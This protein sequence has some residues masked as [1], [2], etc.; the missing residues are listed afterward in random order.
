MQNVGS[1]LQL[2]AIEEAAEAAAKKSQKGA[3]G[4]YGP[5]PPPRQAIEAL[6]AHVQTCLESL[7]Q[8]TQTHATA[9][10]DLAV[11]AHV[12]TACFAAQTDAG[13]CELME[14]QG[15]CSSADKGVQAGATQGRGKSGPK[16][17]AQA[18]TSETTALGV[19]KQLLALE[20]D[21]KALR[22]G[23]PIPCLEWCA[24]LHKCR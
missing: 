23:M 18:D 11:Q 19:Y 2:V 12:P 5:G 6:D 10:R 13:G 15:S 20:V 21:S 4:S 17:R 9:C 7:S 16:T 8:L 22:R 3:S 24:S 1:V 14:V